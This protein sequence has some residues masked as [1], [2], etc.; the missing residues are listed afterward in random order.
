[1]DG[2]SYSLFILIVEFA[3]GPGD[4]DRAGDAWKKDR[5]GLQWTDRWTGAPLIEHRAREPQE[6]WDR[7][8]NHPTADR[9]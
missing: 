5:H 9:P 7:A 3:D 6:A 1:M 8:S 2:T 4:D